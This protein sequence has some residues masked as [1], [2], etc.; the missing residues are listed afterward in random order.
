M[1]TLV[2]PTLISTTDAFMNYFKEQLNVSEE[3]A[4]KY[5]SLAESLLACLKTKDIE[6]AKSLLG[7]D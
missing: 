2:T 5:T 1:K 6:G 3:N 4:R 7:E